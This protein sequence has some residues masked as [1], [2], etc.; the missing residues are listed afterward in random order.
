MYSRMRA[1]YSANW[2]MGQLAARTI[3]KGV[4]IPR[5]TYAF[6]IWCNGAKW[7]KSHKKLV[8]AQRAPLRAI[9][10]AYNTASSNCLP[11]IA[12]TFPLDLEVQFQALKRK[13]ACRSITPEELELRTEDLMGE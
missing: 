5:I 13:V 10:G 8:S 6:E 11:V 9:T 7:V 1:L 12:G 2:G 4:F 3:Y